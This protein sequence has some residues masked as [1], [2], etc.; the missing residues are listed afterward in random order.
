MPRG[1]GDVKI[2]PSAAKW[3]ILG[4]NDASFNDGTGIADDAV[5]GRHISGFD[6]SNLS[7][8]DSNPYKFFAYHNTTQ[9]L[10]SASTIAFNTELFDTNNNFASNTY[11]AP[12][13]GFYSIRAQ[14]YYQSG[15]T[16]INGISLL[17]NGSDFIRG[18]TVASSGGN[19]ITAQIDAIVELSATNTL[20]TMVVFGGGGS[21]TI[22]GQAATPRYTYFCGHLISRT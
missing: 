21:K 13:D 10:T 1:E 19:D 11:T 14:A 2:Q 18:S 9:S 7:N 5:L 22:Y 8:G 17:K 3:N 6:K 20:T 15:S 16:G 12:I 4:S